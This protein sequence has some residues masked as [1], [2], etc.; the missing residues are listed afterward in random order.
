MNHIEYGVGST[1][2]FYRNNLSKS[3]KILEIQEVF[4]RSCNS[5]LS[6]CHNRLPGKLS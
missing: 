6:V 4:I 3:S 5:C 1:I 2:N